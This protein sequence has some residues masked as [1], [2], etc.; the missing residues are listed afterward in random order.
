VLI[1]TNRW[2]TFDYQ[3]SYFNRLQPVDFRPD[4]IGD[5]LINGLIV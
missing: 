2:K 5:V 4:L 1:M 3:I